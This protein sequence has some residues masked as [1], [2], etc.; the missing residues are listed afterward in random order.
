MPQNNLPPPPTKVSHSGRMLKVCVAILV[1]VLVIALTV[2]LIYGVDS[3]HQSRDSIWWPE[4]GRNLIPPAAIEITLQ[5]DL[6]DHYAIYT[7]SE[8][9]LNSFLDE[10]FSG[11]GEPLDSFSK[12]SRID[13]ADVGRAI[14]RLG[15]V[16]TGS[17]VM[18]HFSASNGGG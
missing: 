1:L 3:H 16:A 4:R 17:T 15:W 14:G 5:R 7:V 6:L 9:D 2:F 8:K 10:R 18:Y 12:R 11:D 13:P